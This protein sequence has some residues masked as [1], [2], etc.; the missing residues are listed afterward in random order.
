MSAPHA[1]RQRAACRGMGPEMFFPEPS[2]NHTPPAA[3]EVC[4][5]CEVSDECLD[6][7]LSIHTTHCF[8]GGVGPK[9]RRNIARSRREG[10]R[11]S[12]PLEREP[13]RNFDAW[14]S[15]ASE[16]ASA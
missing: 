2:D 1:W 16:E 9:D 14:A 4:G 5:R 12:S 6:Y 8:W 13:V 10:A 15:R 7:A 11:F 3:R